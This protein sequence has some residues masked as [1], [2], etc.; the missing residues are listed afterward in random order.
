VFVDIHPMNI[1]E[2]SRNDVRTIAH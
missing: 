1:V 2:L